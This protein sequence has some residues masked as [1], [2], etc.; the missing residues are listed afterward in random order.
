MDE[1]PE[2]QS[3]VVTSTSHESPNISENPWLQ[4]ASDEMRE[5]VERERAFKKNLQEKVLQKAAADAQD[6]MESKKPFLPLFSNS[7]NG[8]GKDSSTTLRSARP[9]IW[10]SSIYRGL[11]EKAA[12][13]SDNVEVETSDSPN[14]S[15]T[16]S[17]P[18]G[19][20]GAL[21]TTSSDTP[22][23]EQSYVMDMNR[24]LMS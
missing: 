23:V 20:D 2:A 10:G 18:D 16:V 3:S 14:E 12:N 22:S 11:W 1:N 13:I 6:A 4:L 9:V 8:E 21:M 7:S 19:C 5:C 24:C 15:A 17:T